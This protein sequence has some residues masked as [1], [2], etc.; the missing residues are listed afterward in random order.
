MKRIAQ[1]W[2]M[3][4]LCCGSVYAADPYVTGQYRL[5]DQGYLVELTI[6][7]LLL[8]GYISDFTVFT[9]DAAGGIG[10]TGWAALKT[11]RDVQW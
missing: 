9:S 1:L 2:F 8:E 10:P 7:N 3:L 6:H 4:M 5:I 11:N